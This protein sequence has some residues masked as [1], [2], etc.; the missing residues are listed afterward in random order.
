M[1]EIKNL[2][3]FL[4]SMKETLVFDNEK[5]FNEKIKK[6]RKF[7]IKVQKLVYLSKFFGWKNEYHFNFHQRGPYSVELTQD[8]NKLNYTLISSSKNTN[9][10]TKSFKEFI[11]NQDLEFFE[12][13]S[14]ILYYI[15]KLNIQTINKNTIVKNK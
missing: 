8:Y 12:A 11:K 14:T 2:A 7:R 1:T 5:D 3:Y 9:L 13:T 4:N 15:G 10:T 6:N